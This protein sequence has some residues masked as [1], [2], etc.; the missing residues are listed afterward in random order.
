MNKMEST[1]FLILLCLSIFLPVR[2]NNEKEG[3]GEHMLRTM[4]R[5]RQHSLRRFA[6]DKSPKFPTLEHSISSPGFGTG[7]L[8]VGSLQCPK[9]RFVLITEYAFGRTGNHMIEFTHGLWIAEKLQSTLIVPNW[10]KDIFTPFNSSLLDSLYCYTVDFKPPS[11]SK[12]FEVTSEESFFPFQLYNN[13]EY[14]TFLPP[15]RGNNSNATI[16]EISLHFLQVYAALWSSPHKK[17][18]LATE[19]FIYHFLDGNFRYSTVHKRL[20][21]GGCSNIL[22]SNTKVHD[23]SINELPMTH[24]EWNNNL[25]K[26]H[27]LCDMSYSF[28]LETL[29]MHHRESSKLFVAYDT[30]G[31]CED[32]KAAGAVFSSVLKDHSDIHVDLDYKFLE[33]FLAIHG[34]FFI[35]NPRSTFSWQIFLVRMILSLSSVPLVKNN[36]FYLQKVPEDLNAGK[37]DLWVSWTS[38]VDVM[39]QK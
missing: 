36:D 37:R 27:P 31:G 25:R 30:Y 15:I 14:Q 10:M 5:L 6:L 16:S 20:L 33:M 38:I 4:M 2:S 23:F 1:F 11:G 21:E 29:K 32:Y 39:M 17:L 12:V 34:D 24:T 35:M 18:L 28:V 26:N 22:G 8:G 19:Y 9:D 13:K 7:S 3:N